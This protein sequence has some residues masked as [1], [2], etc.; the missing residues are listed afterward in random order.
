MSRSLFH[1][2][3]PHLSNVHQL[4]TQEG[5]RAVPLVAPPETVARPVIDM[6]PAPSLPALP[7]KTSLVLG[8]AT[9]DHSGRVR[10][11][12]VLA[13]LGWRPGDRTQAAVRG[14]TV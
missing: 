7:H 2:D 10:D 8:L 9:V 1:R 12:L 11:R 3:A 5:V 4:L 14:T 6:L 13:A